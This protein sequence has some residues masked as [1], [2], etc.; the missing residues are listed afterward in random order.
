MGPLI[1]GLLATKRLFWVV[2]VTAGCLKA[3]YDLGMLAPF[4][5]HKTREGHDA[6]ER[7]A[8]EQ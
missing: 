8:A 6:E 4:A 5:G 3:T 1:T 2:F 7:A